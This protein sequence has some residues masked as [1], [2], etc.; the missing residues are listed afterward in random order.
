MTVRS[1]LAFLEFERPA[2]DHCCSLCNPHS[3][4]DYETHCVPVRRLGG[5]YLY[6]C[7]ACL[8]HMATAY[9]EETTQTNEAT[10][11]SW[12]RLAE[13]AVERTASGARRRLVDSDD[14]SEG[15]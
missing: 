7:L 3:Y 12:E 8:R 1:E 2:P 14:E 10:L 11:R 9:A 4:A 13:L 15:P 5:N 6:V